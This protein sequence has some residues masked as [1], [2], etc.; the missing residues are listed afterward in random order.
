MTV[1][2]VD[3]IV[4]VEG[5]LQQIVDRREKLNVPI[6]SFIR[7]PGRL[8]RQGVTFLVTIME[9]VSGK[10][11]QVPIRVE[12]EEILQYRFV[13]KEQRTWWRRKYIHSIKARFCH[14]QV[15]LTKK[16]LACLKSAINHFIRKIQR[17]TH[18]DNLLLTKRRR[19]KQAFHRP[20]A[21]LMR[22]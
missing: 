14:D 3:P 4:S 9:T 5:V 22:H 7:A 8:L 1:E 18:K 17:I 10:T 16:V 21:C 20:D 13:T 11:D 2:N 15:E 19:H 12:S 6:V